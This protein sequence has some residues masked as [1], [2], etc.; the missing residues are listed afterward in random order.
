MEILNKNRLSGSLVVA[1]S[2]LC[3]VIGWQQT[4]ATKAVRTAAA[5]GRSGIVHVKGLKSP[6][7][8]FK[9]GVELSGPST[10]GSAPAIAL[11]AA[12]FDSDGTPDLVTADRNGQ[13]RFSHGNADTIYPNTPAAKTHFASNGGELSPFQPASNRV[14][15]SFAPDFFVAG[16]FNADGKSDILATSRGADSLFLLSGNGKGDFAEPRTIKLNG[17]VTAFTVGEIGRRDGQTDVAVAIQNKEG[18]QLLVF[19]HPEGAFKH[20]PEIFVLPSAA[21]DLAIGQ[22]DADSYGDIAIAGGNNLTIVHGRGQAYPLDLKADLNIKRPAAFMQTRQFAF[23]ISALAIGRFTASRGDSLALLATDG[24][25]YTLEPGAPATKS[26]TNKLTAEALQGTKKLSFAPVQAES[27][28]RKFA[29]LKVE[30]PRTEQEADQSGQLMIDSRLSQKDREKFIREKV[31][32]SASDF[33]KLSRSEQ[34]KITT[35]GVQRTEESNQKR[36][37]GFERTLSSLPIPLANFKVEALMSDAR[38]MNAAHS[39]STHKLI[40]ARFSDSDKD[41]LVLVD[42]IGKQIQIIAQINNEDQSPRTELLSLDSDAAPLAILP[43]RLNSDALSDLV[44]LREGSAVPTVL[45]TASALTLVVNTTDN[46]S[47]GAC[48]GTDPCALRRAIIIA[49][50]NPGLDTIT[51]NIPGAGVHTIHPV[52]ALPDVTGAVVIDGTTQP[53]FAGKPLIEIEGDLLSGANEG[54]KVRASNSVIRGLAIN[55]IPSNTQ[56]A[57]QI[58]GSGITVLS[59]SD[60]PNVTNVIVEG[61]FLGTDPTGEFKKGNDGNGVH[62]FFADSNTVG[63]TTPQARNILSGNGKPSEQKTGVGLAVTG[64]NNNL[65]LGNYIGADA[66]GVV[67]LGNSYGVYFTGKNNQFG[68]DAAGAGNLVSGNGG[69]LNDHN[70]CVGNG[71]F[72]DALFL[73]WYCNFVVFLDHLLIVSMFL[74]PS[75]HL[76]YDD[77]HYPYLDHLVYRHHLVY[78]YHHLVYDDHLVHH[79]YY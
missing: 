10:E 46:D 63:G 54:L 36:K 75:H 51:F 71:I 33:A 77:H 38:L 19:E 70:Q 42:S 45:A 13:V 43:M 31:E 24:S 16:D 11:A 30:L 73:I 8:N 48:D 74:F 50:S 59:T 49:N 7:I 47:G 4:A 53:G 26:T 23:D 35:E 20:P 61:N 3:A 66:S 39:S 56:D 68:G 5:E 18:A 9:D 12:D 76:V 14:L 25:I 37:E 22:L 44:I 15:L 34:N 58:G 52:S 57:S 62:I 27:E 55:H 21:T 28:L 40:T 72:V 17:Q 65:I 2:F 64:G 79:H 6:H 1:V 69:P 78:D 41:G 29:A 67:K 32:R 60:S